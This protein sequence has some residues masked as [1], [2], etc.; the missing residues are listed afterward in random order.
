[1]KKS[2]LMFGL[3]GFGAVMIGLWIYR[4]INPAP[5]PQKSIYV[6]ESNKSRIEFGEISVTSKKD[7]DDIEFINSLPR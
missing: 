6:A 7:W 5:N 4:K 1:M 2:W 3:A